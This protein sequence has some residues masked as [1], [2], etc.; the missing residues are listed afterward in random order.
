MLLVREILGKLDD[1]RFAGRRVE[2]LPVDWAQAGKRRLRVDTDCGTD[3]AVD[4]PRG[5]YLADG[6][7]LDDDGERVV[8]VAR[9]S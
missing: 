5:A 1:P 3:V 2:R 4:L 8:V 7:V 6:A 9:T